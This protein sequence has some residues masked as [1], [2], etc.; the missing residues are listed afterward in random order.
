MARIRG[1]CRVVLE[2]QANGLGLDAEQQAELFCMFRRLY[3]HV[4]GSGAGLYMVKKMVANAGGTIAVASQPEVG[5]TFPV[6]L[7]NAG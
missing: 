2:V 1:R 5:T 6:F 4:P 3:N 7:P